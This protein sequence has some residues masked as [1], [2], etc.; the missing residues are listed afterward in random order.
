MIARAA[1]VAMPAVMIAAIGGSAAR[2]EPAPEPDALPRFAWEPFGYLRLQYPAVQNDPGALFVGRD[3]GFELQN[4]R[5][6]V[7][8]ALGGRIAFVV[9]IGGAVRPSGLPGRQRQSSAQ[10]QLAGRAMRRVAHAC[11][12]HLRHLR[13]SVSR[14]RRMLTAC[15]SR[16]RALCSLQ[17]HPLWS[18][19]R[20]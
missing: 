14:Q 18:A 1:A 16:S 2:A 6:G 11:R 17:F 19:R 13:G 4:A 8:G 12:S 15:Q 20:P 5:V 9:A 7:R 3:D 10:S